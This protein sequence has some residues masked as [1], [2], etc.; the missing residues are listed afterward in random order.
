MS[1]VV[2]MTGWIMSEHG[3][4]DS[5]LTV[6]RRGNNASNGQT[7]W[8]CQCGCG[9]KELKLIRGS[10][11]RSGKILSC[12]CFIKEKASKMFKKHNRYNIDGDFAIGFTED[13]EEFWVD[14]EFVP[15]LNNFY[16]WY[17]E[18]GYLK[19]KNPSNDP[20]N[21][22]RKNIYLHILVMDGYNL[23]V[24]P[25]KKFVDHKTHPERNGKKFDNRLSNLRF[26]T[27]GENN[28]NQCL[29]KRNTSGTTGVIFH[30]Q[31]GKWK[32]QIVIN[33]E[34]IYLGLYS[35]LQDAINARKNAELKY[36]GEYRYDA[37]N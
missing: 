21:I 10:H 15:M 30:K 3:I 29:S 7:Q 22:G 9:N 5:R 2:D 23:N 4:E 19:A 26:A 1:K 25:D 17:D 32:A 8:W 31:T 18:H 6:V 12:G 35:N 27:N 16:F 20:L 13:N 33:K 37:N 28:Q 24:N 34:Y 36:F 11:I 14:K